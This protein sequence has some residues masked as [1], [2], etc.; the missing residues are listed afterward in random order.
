MELNLQGACQNNLSFFYH[1]FALLVMFVAAVH[2]NL[3]ELNCDAT[4]LINST[5]L[6]QKD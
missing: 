1:V 6:H 4:T 3:A 2:W 5:L